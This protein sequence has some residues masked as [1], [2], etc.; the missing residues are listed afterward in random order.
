VTTAP[1]TGPTVAILHPTAPILD[2]T[3]TISGST[4]AIID[5]TGMVIH[6]NRW[7]N[8]E[9]SF[10]WLAQKSAMIQLR[11]IMKPAFLKTAVLAAFF[12]CTVFNA[13]AAEPVARGFQNRVLTD[14]DGAKHPFVIFVPA[15]DQ[16]GSRAPVMLFLHG[17]GERG[18][19]NIDQIM[20][21]LGPAIWKR[22]AN[23]PFVTVIPQCRTNSN[24]L[25]D[26]PDAKRALAM[27]K[28]TQAEFG[29]D[30]DRVYLTGLSMGGS[31][32]WSIAAKDPS[33]WAAIVPMCSRTDVANAAKFATAR[34]P[35]WDFCG[36]KDRAET[37]KFSRDMSAALAQL[38]A[39]AKYT[40]Y[41]GV[42]HNCWDNAYGTDELYTWLL[43]QSRSRNAGK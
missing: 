5:A 22:K 27:L 34:L 24:W 21:G 1:I 4:V 39:P 20:V 3:G 37:V 38:K 32:T 23:F 6:S 10:I 43:E 26:G 2:P 40:E 7:R 16:P 11:H 15:K 12:T 13:P 9:A 30:P 17:S 25:A 42:G 35:I 36:D 18:D 41:P 28:Q 19:N 29:T 14:A 31:G 8:G 33:A